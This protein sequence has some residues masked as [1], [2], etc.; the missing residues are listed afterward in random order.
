MGVASIFSALIRSSPSLVHI[1]LSLFW[2]YLTL[3]R[4]VRKVRRAFEKQLILQGMSKNDAK[5]I[6]ACY[7]ELKNNLV[8]VV[9]KGVTA[10][11]SG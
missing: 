8:A 6:S 9:K 10:P 3:G 11:F 7:D 4:R 1:S 2:T 5:R